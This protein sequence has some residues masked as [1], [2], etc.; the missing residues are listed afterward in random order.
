MSA[1]DDFIFWNALVH[2]SCSS[3]SGTKSFE[4]SYHKNAHS[5]ILAVCTPHY[6]RFHLKNCIIDK[7]IN[8]IF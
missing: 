1:E 6:K 5:M 4:L 3:E 8:I 7:V 2:C